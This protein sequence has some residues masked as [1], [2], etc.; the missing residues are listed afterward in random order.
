MYENGID[1]A[2]EVRVEPT[3]DPETWHMQPHRVTL[4]GWCAGNPQMGVA[5]YLFG[6]RD[7]AERVRITDWQPHV[8]TIEDSMQ[9]F[10]VDRVQVN[11]A[12]QAVA[13]EYGLTDDERDEVSHMI[14]DLLDSRGR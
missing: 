10:L 5:L 1:V 12:L 8:D 4:P 3:P 7:E 13:V 9:E 14:A 6:N 2:Y 11:D